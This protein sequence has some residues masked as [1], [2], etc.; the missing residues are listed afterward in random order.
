MKNTW[1]VAVAAAALIGTASVARADLTLSGQTGLFSNPTAEIVSK[2]GP[3]I[4]GE[5]LHNSE[6]GDRTN[7]YDINGAF[8]AA[9]KLEL[10]GGYGHD[11][12][13]YNYAGETGTANWWHIGG[14]YQIFNQ[15][16]KGFALAAGADYSHYHENYKYYSAD[17][18][19]YAEKD[20][21]L[22]LAATKAF[23]HGDR[24]AVKGT[25]G[26]RWDK[27]D[28]SYNDGYSQSDSKVSVYGG[29][30]VPLTRTGQL[31]A[32]GEL[33]SK[34]YDDGDTVWDLGLRYH[35]KNSGL[36]VGAGF[37]DP[38]SWGGSTWFAQIGYQFGK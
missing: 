16:E 21:L 9:D 14:K 36:S 26:L 35:P 34:R 12:I 10:N 13:H 17:D 1:K 19:S 31:S 20:Y 23:T 30:E 15:N 6:D 22:Y 18:G 8:Q 7:T 33:G 37:G 3:E 38:W 28:G 4:V 27:Y 24:A 32:I 2:K 25:L 5:Y 29:V 11:S